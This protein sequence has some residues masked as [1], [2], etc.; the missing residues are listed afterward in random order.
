MMIEN[1]HDIDGNK[2]S[3]IHLTTADPEW[4]ENQ[5]RVLRKERDLHKR[6]WGVLKLTASMGNDEKTGKIVL[7]WMKE[8]KKQYQ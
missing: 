1:Y 7:R 6:R 4:A 2:C 5:I 8:I 3:L